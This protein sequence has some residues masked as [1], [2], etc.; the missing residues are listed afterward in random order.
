LVREKPTSV[1][2]DAADL[3]EIAAGGGAETADHNEFA[4][5]YIAETAECTAIVAGYIAETADCTEIGAGGGAE[6]TDHS[7]FAADT[8]ADTADLAEIDA[9]IAADNTSNVANEVSS[10]ADN[11]STLADARRIPRTTLRSFESERFGY[12]K[13]VT[14]AAECSAFRLLRSNVGGLRFYKHPVPPAL[15]ANRV[16][17]PQLPRRR[18]LLRIVRSFR[19]GF[20]KHFLDCANA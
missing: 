8:V 5:G 7:E 9:E 1:V 17:L 10:K 6:T 15:R 12:T 14:A 4:A 3:A 13:R 18:R 19:T 11:A 20:R 16:P 2:A